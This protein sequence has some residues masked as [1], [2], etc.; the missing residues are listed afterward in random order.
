MIVHLAIDN[1]EMQAISK[2]HKD[3]GSAWRQHDL[4]LVSGPEFKEL[5]MTN[6][7]ILIGWRQIRDLMNAPVSK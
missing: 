7:I 5:L 3:Y 4:D 6:H 1:D 2:G